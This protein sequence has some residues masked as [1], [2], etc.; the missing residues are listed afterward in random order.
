[1]SGFRKCCDCR[2]SHLLCDLPKVST[3]KSQVCAVGLM[4][5]EYFVLWAPVCAKHKNAW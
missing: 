3:D 4:L 5:P 2:E 1:M